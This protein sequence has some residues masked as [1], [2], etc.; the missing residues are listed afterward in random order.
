MR[1]SDRLR[2]RDEQT[3]HEPQPAAP[4]LAPDIASILAL[5]RTAGNRALQRLMFNTTGHQLGATTDYANQQVDYNGVTRSLMAHANDQ[6]SDFIEHLR[7]GLHVDRLDGVQAFPSATFRTNAEGL[8]ADGPKKAETAKKLGDV[9]LDD[10]QMFKH[11]KGK[12]YATPAEV[13]TSWAMSSPADFIPT[14]NDLPDADADL[15]TTPIKNRTDHMY[16]EYA[17]VLI[18]LVKHDAGLTKTTAILRSTPASE[19][20]AV[21]ALHSHYVKKKLYYDDTSTRFKMMDEWG[22]EPVFT[23]NVTWNDLSTQVTLTPQN[24]YIFDISGHTL[25]ATV[26]RTTPAGKRMP[27]PESFI[28]PESHPENW[29]DK[30]TFG[31][32]I[33]VKFVWKKK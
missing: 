32:D 20:A 9:A 17:C 8:A 12:K 21:Q 31:E 5:Q 23:G 30:E 18:A 7:V 24:K 26:N 4:S 2:R 29:N 25:K 3:G 10:N 28:T 14:G 33:R 11:A 15:K 16:W 1:S 19:D 27:K 6:T 13:E 22:Y